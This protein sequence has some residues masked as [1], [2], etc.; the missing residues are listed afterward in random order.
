MK[1]NFDEIIPRLN[2]RCAKYDERLKKFGTEDLIPLWIADMDFKTAEPII[3]SLK[4]KAEEGIY[5]YVSRPDSYFKAG[6]DWKK[7]RNN[8][9]IDES[10]CSFSIGVVPAMTI[11][12]EIWCE[13][14][15][16]ILI[17]PPIY[18]EFFEIVENSGNSILKNN[19]IKKDGKWCIDW[20]DFE[21]KL[22]LASMFLFCNPHNPL[23]IVWE[24][25]EVER[26][27]NFCAKYNVILISDEIHSDLIF[28]NK[29]FIP[30]AS[31]NE[32]AKN[33]VISCFSATK[34]FN[35]AG[36]Q[37]CTVVFPN[38]KLKSEFDKWWYAKDIHRNNS[39]SSVAM[40]VAYNEGEEWLEQLLP[41]ID[42]NFKFVV[43]Y[44]KKYIPKIKTF[45]PDATYLMWLDCQ[46]LNLSNEKLDEFMVKKAKLG[47]SSGIAFD[48][49]LDGFMRLNVACPISILK[50]AL[51]Q[52]KK[53]VDK[54]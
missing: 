33:T 39:F 31:V 22:K 3:K 2:T 47:L 38:N 53:A 36:L 7:R 50:Q 6:C 23:G 8:W 24:K 51:E 28:N 13:N 10:L 43:E 45:I 19:L 18:G 30:T 35:L 4:Q 16:K 32:L 44:C 54:L 48:K 20:D 52:L 40:E 34:T 49:E 41:Y 42:N 26:I 27:V 29:K 17:Q 37:A 12:A 9:D 25:N 5:G 46:E 14:G 21:N 1:Y 15:S 11:M